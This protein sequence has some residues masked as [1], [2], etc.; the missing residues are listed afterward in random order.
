LTI[1]A[2]AWLEYL[3]TVKMSIEKHAGLLSAVSLILFLRGGKE[4][5]L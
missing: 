4:M 1:L 3:G 5:G 2:K